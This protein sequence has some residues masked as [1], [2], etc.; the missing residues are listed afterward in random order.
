M[1]SE[2]PWRTGERVFIWVYY[3][4]Y[5]RKIIRCRKAICL[6]SFRFWKTIYQFEVPD[7]PQFQVTCSLYMIQYCTKFWYFGSP[8]HTDFGNLY[9]IDA[10][11][12]EATYKLRLSLTPLQVCT[13]FQS[14]LVYHY[15]LQTS[16]L[17]HRLSNLHSVRQNCTLSPYI[18]CNFQQIAQGYDCTDD[19][20]SFPP[21]LVG[22]VNII[23]VKISD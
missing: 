4:F 11:V 6:S 9:P 23:Y 8:F 5:V 2:E 21:K 3:Q 15:M 10:L 7:S 12:M 22:T 19:T 14:I 1:Y 17:A 20:M 13:I 18:N 16:D